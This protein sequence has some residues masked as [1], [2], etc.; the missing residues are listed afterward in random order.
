L[1][2][3]Q[4]DQA[5]EFVVGDANAKE[6]G[7]VGERCVEVKVLPVVRAMMGAKKDFLAVTWIPDCCASASLRV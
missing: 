5:F 4:A 7:I 2:A 1:Q 3:F 6:G